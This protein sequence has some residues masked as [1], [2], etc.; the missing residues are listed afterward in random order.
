[1][2]C[3]EWSVCDLQ[4]CKYFKEGEECVHASKFK[5]PPT[6]GEVNKDGNDN[7]VCRRDEHD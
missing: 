4:F 3:G 6:E 5:R 1:M 7:E 2:K